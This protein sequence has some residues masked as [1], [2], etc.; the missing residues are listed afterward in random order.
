MTLRVKE[1][2][3]H[4][5][6]RI[7]REEWGYP[8]EIVDTD[9]RGRWYMFGENVVVWFTDE[10]GKA[11][12][13]VHLCTRPGSILYSEGIR[14]VVAGI[15]FL[16]E[17]AD[18]DLVVTN[19]SHEGLQRFLLR[20]GWKMGQLDRDGATWEVCYKRLVEEHANGFSLQPTEPT[21]EAEG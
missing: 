17:L 8:R 1:A 6:A 20:F 12:R 14:R 19:T 7:V 10:L 11:V 13:N 5:L 3:S 21:A 2:F 15:E 9:L 18:A 4:S 16:S